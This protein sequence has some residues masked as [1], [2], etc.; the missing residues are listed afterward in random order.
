MTP[1]VRTHLRIDLAQCAGDLFFY[2]VQ[3]LV[4]VVIGALTLCAC[5]TIYTCT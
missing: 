2:I 1:A 5:A 3:L 4:P